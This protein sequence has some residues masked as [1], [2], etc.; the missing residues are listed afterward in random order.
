MKRRDFITL[1]GCAAAAWPIA[2]RAQ[3]QA[4]PVI[5]YLDTGPPEAISA[6]LSDFRR[7]LKDAG[8]I[9]GR[10]LVIVSRWGNGQIMEQ[11]ARELVRLQVAVI[12]AVGA[13][14]SVKAAAAAT[15]TIPIV[16]EG[17]GD[18]VRLGL[19]ASLNRPGGNVTGITL[20]LNATVGKRL[21]LLLKLVPE[22][23]TIGYVFGD[24][25]ESE[26]D[27]LLA[28]AHDLGRQ[29]IV[30]ECYRPADLESAFATMAEQRAGAV[31]V[32]A[33][34]AAV[35]NRMRVLALAAD[36]RIPAIYAQSQYVRE[37]GLMSY[38]PVGTLQQLAV[39]YVARILKGEKP[40]D[41]PIQQP[42]YFRFII[43]SKTARALGLN[44]P[45]T[46]LAS[47]DEVIE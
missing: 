45:S 35:N 20:A 33:F 8:Y 44:I 24:R 42:V 22:V 23:T 47:A 14:A 5:G 18:P 11:L 46:L 43:N 4:T 15:S 30:L 27:N 25:V 2:A 16:Y 21:D 40:A 37:G 3:Q 41:L 34:P 26:V 36:H 7:G 19:A 1:V 13:I 38:S 6:A 32:G 29:I 31:L 17:G 39:Q 28:S 9:E 12:V 10:N